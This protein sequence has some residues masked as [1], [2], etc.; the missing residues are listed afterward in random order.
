MDGSW[1]GWFISSFV[2][3][4]LLSCFEGKLLW[5]QPPVATTILHLFQI[6]R[7]WH[8]STQCCLAQSFAT[9]FVVLK[10][11]VTMVVAE[12][13]DNLVRLWPL[14]S[15]PGSWGLLMF[16]QDSRAWLDWLLIVNGSSPVISNHHNM[17]MNHYL[18][19]LYLMEFDQ[20]FSVSLLK[21]YYHP[22]LVAKNGIMS[23]PSIGN[24]FLHCLL[25]F[26]KSDQ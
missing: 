4:V 25:R 17:I 9:R 15:N 23:Q 10:V 26:F 8:R 3:H 16:D 12:A 20:Y 1:L 24:H 13:S 21:H 2:I 18:W 11:C 5:A 19:M 14:V 22:L 6:P 7:A